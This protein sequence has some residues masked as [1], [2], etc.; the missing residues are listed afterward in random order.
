MLRD[1]SLDETL[2]CST[3]NYLVVP[4]SSKDFPGNEDERLQL[5]VEVQNVILI[6]KFNFY[7]THFTCKAVKYPWA[8]KVFE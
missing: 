2:I 7:Q 6:T 3:I 5:E 8:F 4:Y 1:H